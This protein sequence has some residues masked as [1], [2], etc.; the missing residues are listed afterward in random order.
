MNVSPEYAESLFRFVSEQHGIW[1]PKRGKSQTPCVNDTEEV[2]HGKLISS[3]I[4]IKK[5]KGETF[6]WDVG[7]AAK[8]LA[9]AGV[10]YN[11]IPSGRYAV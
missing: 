6:E 5:K 11:I 1:E 4:I 7:C 8:P 3:N 9:I 2:P 10:E